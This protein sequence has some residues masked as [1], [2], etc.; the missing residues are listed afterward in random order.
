MHYVPRLLQ[1]PG[2]YL[3]AARCHLCV[4]AARRSPP[5]TS[6]SETSGGE[7]G[8]PAGKAGEL[9]RRQ[10]LTFWPEGKESQERDR[11]KCKSQDLTLQNL[12]SESS[13]RRTFF[14][15]VK[16]RALLSSSLFQFDTRRGLP[17]PAPL[18]AGPVKG[19]Y[20]VASGFSDPVASQFSNP[21]VSPSK[22]VTLPRFCA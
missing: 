15:G 18:V 4:S 6:L 22:M 12:L 10:L 14:Q 9:E 3:A 11:V 16:W 2:K 1:G 17:G 19:F 20:L 5:V 13:S 7:C 8:G 21:S